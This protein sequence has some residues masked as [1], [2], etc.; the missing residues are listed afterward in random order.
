MELG[1]EALGEGRLGGGGL[2]GVEL[3]GGRSR[4]VGMPGWCGG[5]VKLNVQVVVRF[6]MWKD[7]VSQIISHL[8]VH[9]PNPKTI[10]RRKSPIFSARPRPNLFKLQCSNHP[11]LTLLPICDTIQSL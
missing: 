11:H 5:I 3:E 7:R 9:F 8:L 2:R 4:L 10:K 1:E 6:P